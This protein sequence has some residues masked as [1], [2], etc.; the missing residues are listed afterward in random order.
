MLKNRLYQHFLYCLLPAFMAS[1][2]SDPPAAGET[3][4]EAV[5]TPVTVSSI[6]RDTLREYIELNATAAFLLKS[7]V[8]ANANGYLQS[9]S[10]RLGQF[11]N[12]GQML[13]TV[14]TKEAESIGNAVNVLDS[15]FRFSGTNSI[16]A[17]ESGY[18]TQLDH[19]P[20]DYVQDGEQLA[21]ISNTN[22]FVFLMNMPYELR[23]YIINKNSVELILPDSEKLQG[24]I[25]AAMPSVD[26]AAQTQSMVIR[27]KA[28]HA[29]PENLVAK[30]RIPKV[31]KSGAIS[32]PKAAILTDETQSNFWIMKMTDSITAVKVPVKKGIETADKV[33]ILSPALSDSDQVLVTGNYGLEDTAKVKIIQPQQ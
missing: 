25:T 15:T 8:K 24:V 11:V 28:G 30:V 23:Q 6:S 5:Q 31:F 7:Y 19:Q 26:S 33:E 9:A 32:V 21:V 18:I 20:G 27:V 22:S 17:G 2:K 16:K 14:K 4:A 1:C 10:I 29:I 3:A 12:R 13:F